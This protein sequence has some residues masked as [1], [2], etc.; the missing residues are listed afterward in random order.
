MTTVAR[1]SS[2]EADLKALLKL[3]EDYRNT[4]QSSPALA[5]AA[6]KTY[7]EK[8]FELRHLGVRAIFL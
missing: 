6:A 5:D 1:A 3:K 8:A 4:V 2:K 7:F